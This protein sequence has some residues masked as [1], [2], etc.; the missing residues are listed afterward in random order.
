VLG[1]AGSAERGVALVGCGRALRQSLTGDGV[2][3]WVGVLQP[4][5]LAGGRLAL[6]GGDAV[7]VGPAGLRRTPM[8]GGGVRGRGTGR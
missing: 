6:E 8:R 2:H 4:V 3:R 1:G 5:L 7:R